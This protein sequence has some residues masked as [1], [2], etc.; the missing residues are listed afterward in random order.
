ML[1]KNEREF[2][3]LINSCPLGE[4]RRD[5]VLNVYRKNISLKSNDTAIKKIEK[6]ELKTALKKHKKCFAERRSEMLLKNL[7]LQLKTNNSQL[8]QF[9]KIQV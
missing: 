5:C 3:A 7:R 8:S 4:C 6:N 9:Y 1:N 2:A